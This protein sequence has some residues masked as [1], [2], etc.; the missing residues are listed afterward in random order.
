MGCETALTYAKHCKRLRFLGDSL[1]NSKVPVEVYLRDSRYE[2]DA[3]YVDGEIEE[4]PMEDF[5]NADWQQAIQRWFAEH[6]EVWNIKAFSSLRVKV[7][8]TRYRV[9]DVTV[10]GR[11]NR[12]EQI[13]TL[14]PIAVFEIIGQE[15]RFGN[16]L[17][18][19]N[20]YFL[21]GIP[22]IW[23]INPQDGTSFRYVDGAFSRQTRFREN[24]IDFPVSAFGA[25]LQND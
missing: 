24:E 14:P 3:E 13:T 1:Q 21:M 23:L 10:I 11:H 20:D 18:K 17:R 25:L 9:P 12:R 4:R 19:M 22:Q 15:D 5:D 16:M 7:A 6:G 8:P 2:P